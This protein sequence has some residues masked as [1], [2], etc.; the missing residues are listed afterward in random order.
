MIKLRKTFAL[1]IEKFSNNIPRLNERVEKSSYWAQK[2]KLSLFNV[3]VQLSCIVFTTAY[4]VK[5]LTGL[6]IIL[7]DCREIV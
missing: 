3:T 1:E 4:F 7:I 5:L 6:L 2:L